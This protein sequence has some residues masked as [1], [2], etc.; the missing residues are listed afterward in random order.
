VPPK[1]LRCL[2]I[3]FSLS[4]MCGEILCGPQ[5][6]VV[7]KPRDKHH[8][9]RH[10]VSVAINF[11][12]WFCNDVLFWCLILDAY[13]KRKFGTY[14]TENLAGRS[15]CWVLSRASALLTS[16]DV[17]VKEIWYSGWIWV[18]MNLRSRSSSMAPLNGA[19][20]KKTAKVDSQKLF[21]LECI[22]GD[23]LRQWT[24]HCLIRS[25]LPDMCC[26]FQVCASTKL[27]VGCHQRNHNM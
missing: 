5:I 12:W 20:V 4:Y 17:L 18:N 14:E 8:Q 27:G 9:R 22:L 3:W 6:W 26:E 24:H 10:N 25:M 16:L 1:K 13:Y 19:H 7:M 21:P 23:R 2:N 15:H 11:V